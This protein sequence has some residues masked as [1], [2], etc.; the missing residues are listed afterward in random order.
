MNVLS[1]F[2]NADA[3]QFLQSV[4]SARAGLRQLT[5]DVQRAN[6]SG[7][8]SYSGGAMRETADLGGGRSIKIKRSLDEAEETLS[9]R[10]TKWVG[11]AMGTA[12]AIGMALDA[13]R[14]IGEKVRDFFESIQA[15][16]IEAK[17]AAVNHATKLGRGELVN[18]GVVDRDVERARGPQTLEGMQSQ[19]SV[20]KQSAAALYRQGGD[21]AEYQKRVREIIAMEDEIAALVRE[22]KES[23][24]RAAD[25][26][27]QRAEDAAQYADEFADAE[28]ER[29]DYELSRKGL[30]EQLAAK[31]KQLAELEKQ[32]EVIQTPEGIRK[33][34]RLR[35]EIDDILDA[36]G[37]QAAEAAKANAEAAEKEAKAREDAAEQAARAAEDA[38]ERARRVAD[39]KYDLARLGRPTGDWTD[40]ATLS[41][42]AAARSVG[43]YRSPLEDIAA[44]QRDLL[45]IIADNSQGP[46]SGGK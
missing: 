26:A 40:A 41:K 22:R 37:K 18:R 32:E 39:A 17:T 35:K 45:Q 14:R 34:T 43:A 10:I 12:F 44:E 1:Y 30:D 28:G 13:G 4:R 38:K 19:L 29:S 5:D 16:I 20:L 36:K 31:R 3:R 33:G 42:E 6:Q 9:S 27:A 23:E 46:R 11:A 15:A 2:I 25:A 7:A 24:Q 21:S 8:M